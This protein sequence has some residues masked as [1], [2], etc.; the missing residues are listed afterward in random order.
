MSDIV[1]RL[2]RADEFYDLSGAS[3]PDMCVEFM[4]EAA[5]EIEQLREVLTAIVRDI[6]DYERTNNLAPNPG[7]SECWDSVA[8]AK[9]LLDMK[10]KA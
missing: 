6:N 10:E 7:R 4:L 2:L 5:N 3:F 8:R 9:H 1:E